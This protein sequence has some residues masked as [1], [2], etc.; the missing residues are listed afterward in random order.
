MKNNDKDID[1][2]KKCAK[3]FEGVKGF[4]WERLK[5]KYT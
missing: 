5:L 1:F 3:R 2:Q 4:L